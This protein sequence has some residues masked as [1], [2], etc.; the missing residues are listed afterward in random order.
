MSS[1]DLPAPLSHHRGAGWRYQQDGAP[2]HRSLSTQGWLKRNRVRLLN[3]GFW[4]PMSPDLNPIEHL[5]VI[6]TRKLCGTVFAGKDQLWDALRE[7][8]AS[9]SPAEIQRLYTSM[10]SRLQCVR[11]ARG[12]P[13]RY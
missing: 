5:W 11:A 10:Q 9:V 2:V 1:P 13:T 6:L 3:R 12:G 7:A 4:P 8:C